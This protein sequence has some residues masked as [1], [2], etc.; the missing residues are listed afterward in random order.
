MGE[1]AIIERAAAFAALRDRDWRSNWYLGTAEQLL[2]A[3]VIEHYMLDRGYPPCGEIST[4][5]EF[6]NHLT[7][8][9]RSDGLLRVVKAIN[10]DIRAPKTIEKAVR[11]TVDGLLARFARGEAQT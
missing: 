9:R 8:R 3:G 2:A 4:K 1:R 10:D 7:I 11:A 6:G 5:D